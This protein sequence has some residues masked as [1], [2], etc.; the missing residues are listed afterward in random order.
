MIPQPIQP[1]SK[2]FVL[3]QSEPNIDNQVLMHVSAQ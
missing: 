2:Y 1:F 3:W